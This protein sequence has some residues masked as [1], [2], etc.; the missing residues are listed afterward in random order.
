MKQSAIKRIDIWRLPEVLIIQLKKF[1]SSGRIGTKLH[2]FVDFPIKDLDVSS[3]IAQKNRQQPGRYMLYAIT[4]HWG[5]SSTS[6]HYTVFAKV[7]FSSGVVGVYSGCYC[8]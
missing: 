2:T 7:K 1:S 8:T 5:P 3:Y 6:G 4:N